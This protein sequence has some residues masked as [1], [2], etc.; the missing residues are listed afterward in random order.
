MLVDPKCNWALEHLECFPVEVNRADYSYLRF[1]F[2]GIGIICME[3]CQSKKN[4]NIG[5]Y[6]FKEDGGRV[7]ESVIFSDL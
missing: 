2:R 6:G 7:K 3:E 4:G 5:F 1:G